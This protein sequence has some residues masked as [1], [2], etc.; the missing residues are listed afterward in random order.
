MAEM[1][2]LQK[3]PQCNNARNLAQYLGEFTSLMKSQGQGSSD[4]HKVSMLND[5]LPEDALQELRLARLQDGPYQAMIQHL[6]VEQHKFVDSRVAD[7]MAA[8][9]FAH[10][11]GQ[12]KVINSIVEDTAQPASHKPEAV[13]ADSTAEKAQS[14]VCCS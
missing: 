2:S 8:Q 6:R 14:G 3:L 12:R 1:K 11:P 4:A 13:A 9:Q 5:M 10:L 7:A